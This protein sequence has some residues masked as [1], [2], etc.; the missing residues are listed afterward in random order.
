MKNLLFLTTVSYGSMESWNL[1]NVSEAI[2][3]TNLQIVTLCAKVAK[4]FSVPPLS[5]F[6]LSSTFLDGA[7]C[8][9]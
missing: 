1:E 5:N 6:N 2:I 9:V 8:V 4:H 3:L 7:C